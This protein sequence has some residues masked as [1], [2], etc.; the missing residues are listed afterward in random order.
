MD[1]EV[2]D[3]PRA[4]SWFRLMV[5]AAP[6]AMIVV[7]RDRR[8]ILVNRGTE[9]MFGYTR[10]ELIGE[11]IECLVPERL[12]GAHARQVEAFTEDPRA[13]AMGGGRELLG[14]RKDGTEVPIEIG[15]NPIRTPDG[16]Y[17]LA[18]IIDITERKR[19]DERF[20]LA[21]EASPSAMVMADRH[22]SITLVNRK[23][24]ELFGYSREELVGRPLEKLVP[25]RFRAKHPEHVERFFDAA[26]AR[27]MGSGRELFGR[28]KDGTEVPV[29]IGLNPIET[30]DGLY[31][32]ASIIDITERRRAEEE[33]R[34]SNADLEQF[35]AIA[36][37]DLQEPLRMVASYT[38]LLAQRYQG[39]LDEKADRYIFYAVDG[40]KRMQRLV[41]DLLAYSRVGAEGKALVPVDSGVVLK[42]VLD[43]LRQALLSAEVSVECSPLPVVLADEGQLH[44]LFQNLIGNAIK[45]RGLVAPRV[46]VQARFQENHWLFSV[47]DNGIGIE[48][49]H[50]D[51]IFQMFQR[52]HERGKYEGSGIGLAIAKRILERHGGRIWFESTPGSG[53]TFHFTLQPASTRPR[54]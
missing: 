1:S 13:R 35:A 48:T 3:G 22:R 28:R 14:R 39:K 44:Q 37:H 24:E 42:N 53:T 38:E 54:S 12:R 5:E 31:T 50:G 52:L 45:F 17:T 23:V 41:S 6:N 10:E 21:V 2:P 19:A 27:P 16:L 51:R 46:A 34:R 25:E 8:I 32:L 30:E 7:E 11:R 40:A 20:R 15:L 18:S 33:L 4:E 43:V 47:E 29:E 9:F 49:Q 26:K 36:S